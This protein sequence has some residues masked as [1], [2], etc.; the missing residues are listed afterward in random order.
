MSNVAEWL[1]DNGYYVIV[2]QVLENPS[3]QEIQDWHQV[4]PK[5]YKIRVLE[6]DIKTTNQFI[7]N[8][9]R[10]W[11]D[12]DGQMVLFR[13]NFRPRARY[14]YFTYCMAVPRKSWSRDKPTTELTNK[15]GKPYWGTT[16]QFM[17]KRT[18]CWCLCRNLGMS[19][20]FCWKGR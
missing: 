10:R 18:C 15:L 2:P 13:R 5:N 17:K 3:A 20:K 12:L 19:M 7:G 9:E 1:F 6:P 4:E 14:L 16:S 8:S 11:R